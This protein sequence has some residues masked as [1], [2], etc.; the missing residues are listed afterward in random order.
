[1]QI[2]SMRWVSFF[3]KFVYI[4]NVCFLVSL[5]LQ[6]LKADNLPQWLVGTLVVLGWF[7]FGTLMNVIF[8]LLTLYLFLA[9]KRSSLP[10]IITLM[11]IAIAVFQFIYFLI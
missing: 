4:C 6:Y 7:P 3:A 1:M 11:N 8:L 9:G 5:L 2:T 10:V